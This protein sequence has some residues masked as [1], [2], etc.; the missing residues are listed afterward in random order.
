MV[1]SGSEMSQKAMSQPSRGQ[2]QGV[3]AALAP[4]SPCD[5]CDLAVEL[6][7]VSPQEMARTS[8]SDFRRYCS[9][10][11]RTVLSAACPVVH[12]PAYSRS[13]VGGCQATAP[14]ARLV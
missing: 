11:H 4:G 14:G 7:H 9:L 10:S 3:A 8:E 1:F 13:Q 2:R 6:A 5:Q 12:V